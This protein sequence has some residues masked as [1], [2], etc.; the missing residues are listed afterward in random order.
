M[1]SQSRESSDAIDSRVDELENLK[2][3]EE[4]YHT[5]EETRTAEPVE[6]K[7]LPCRE[8]CKLEDK[9]YEKCKTR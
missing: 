2:K 6:G 1:V 5:A 4:I 9:T 8:G 3:D 7:A